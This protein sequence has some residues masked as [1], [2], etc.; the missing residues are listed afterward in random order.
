MTVRDRKIYHLNQRSASLTEFLACEL[1]QGSG[2]SGSNDLENH[3][4]V[5]RLNP[6]C[7]KNG[8]RV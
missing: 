4:G 7:L 5:L 3:Q 8:A 2:E 1:S 6:A